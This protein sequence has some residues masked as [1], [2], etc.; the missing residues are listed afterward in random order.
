MNQP[1]PTQTEIKPMLPVLPVGVAGYGAYVTRYR[2]PATEVA[3]VWTGNTGN[4]LPV[5]TAIFGDNSKKM[6]N[7]DPK[8]AGIENDRFVK[9]KEAYLRNGASPSN[10]RYGYVLKG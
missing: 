7:Y 4:S 3:R 6:Y 5:K 10:L 2:L 9:I 1:V 8:K